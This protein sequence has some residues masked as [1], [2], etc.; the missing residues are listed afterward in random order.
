MSAAKSSAQRKRDAEQAAKIAKFNEHCYDGDLQDVKKMLAFT[1]PLTQDDDACFLL[2]GRDEEGYTAL[3]CAANGNQLEVV[4]LLIEKGADVNAIGNDGFE[5]SVLFRAAFVG[6]D[7]I[8]NRLLDEGANPYIGDKAG[9]LP[10]S[11]AP[12][13][14][15]CQ[16]RLQKLTI[17]L[18]EQTE[19]KIK[20]KAEFMGLLQ[21]KRSL[22]LKKKGAKIAERREKNLP[23]INECIGKMKDEEGSVQEFKDTVFKHWDTWISLIFP[24]VNSGEAEAITELTTDTKPSAPE[25]LAAE[26]ELKNARKNLQTAMETLKILRREYDSLTGDGSGAANDAESGKDG[27]KFR[28]LPLK[29]L[30]DAMIKNTSDYAIPPDIDRWPLIWEPTPGSNKAST[31][32]NYSGIAVITLFEGANPLRNLRRS[33]L[34][35]IIKGV[36]LVIDLADDWVEERH[37]EKLDEL[38]ERAKGLKFKD[39]K[40]RFRFLD[41]LLYSKEMMGPASYM[42][43]GNPECGTVLGE[44]EGD[45]PF[46]DLLVNEEMDGTDYM[47]HQYS[48]ENIGKF[49][50]IF[51]SRSEIPNPEVMQK[52][53]VRRIN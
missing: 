37:F 50:L 11:V 41:S 43:F 5:R 14:Y 6:A 31:F 52:F 35:A 25:V 22:F 42:G 28:V 2:E 49:R 3:S 30:A 38:F 8:V 39:G 16:K 27:F 1:D 24:G 46:F 48:G 23:A 20:E 9:E 51:L 36:P 17:D 12:E 13:G 44:Q 34:R 29:F 7:E 19:E 21:E 47:R 15:T 45:F 53:E 40:S 18:N 4:E 33:L 26:V 32:F 10:L